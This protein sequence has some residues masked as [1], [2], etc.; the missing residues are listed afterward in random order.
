[1][2]CGEVVQGEAVGRGM[3]GGYA[4][5]HQHEQQQEQQ[6]QQARPAAAHTATLASL[7]ARDPLQLRLPT[8][9]HGRHAA[10]SVRCSRQESDVDARVCKR[11]HTE[12][13]HQH[14]TLQQQQQQQHA[15]QAG[16]GA[17]GWSTPGHVHSGTQQR[18]EEPPQALHLVLLHQAQQLQQ[19][20]QQ[21][22]QQQQ[23]QKQQQREQ[24]QEW[25]Q[26]QARPEAAYTA[27]L[28]SL[29]ARDM[30]QLRPPTGAPSRHAAA[31]ASFSL[32]VPHRSLTKRAASSDLAFL[33]SPD[34]HTQRGDDT[35]RYHDHRGQDRCH[36][37][38]YQLDSAPRGAE[39][40]RSQPHTQWLGDNWQDDRHIQDQMASTVVASELYHTLQLR[41]EPCNMY[42]LP[43][44]TPASDHQSRASLARA[45]AL[46]GCA[47]LPGGL[48]YVPVSP[49]SMLYHAGT[50]FGFTTYTVALGSSYIQRLC[51]A[52][53][54]L[55]DV[56]AD[57]GTQQ[58]YTVREY[59]Y[60]TI[61]LGSS[62][63]QRLCA[64]LPALYDAVAASPRVKQ[65]VRYTRRPAGLVGADVQLGLTREL[66]EL[67]A[68]I[69][70]VMFTCVYLACKVVDALPRPNAL[71]HILRKIFCN[72][73]ID[74]AQVYQVQSQALDGLRWRL[75]PYFRHDALSEEWSEV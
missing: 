74:F 6:A 28:S 48:P 69:N 17:F 49:D 61:A 62:Y 4:H 38:H 64:A 24:Q 46:L 73:T 1:M 63:F 53:S 22:K 30:L 2:R 65:Y 33:A 35:Q 27:T 9:V 39:P 59:A 37:Y 26:Q 16:A 41:S 42:R 3:A 25:Q 31:S 67:D 36:D 13:S 54:A 19:Q 66:D 29:S 52:L 18:K 56:V 68:S 44:R 70:A 8:G 23:Q 7:S 43:R 72:E 55:Y 32:Q 5:T 11:P 47:L 75:G 60:Y 57:T 20:Q 34:A 15:A 58:G 21:Q 71:R 40:R 10:A 45:N 14:Q 12:S 50:A 51:A